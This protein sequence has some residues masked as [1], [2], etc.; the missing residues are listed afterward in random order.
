MRKLIAYLFIIIPVLCFG[1]DSFFS[2]GQV[3]KGLFWKYDPPIITVKIDGDNIELTG[4]DSVL[5]AKYDRSYTPTYSLLQS[6]GVSISFKN[7]PTILLNHKSPTEINTQ[8]INNKL[9]RFQSVR[10]TGFALQAVGFA[11]ALVGGFGDSDELITI[12]GIS[13]L[14]GW[15]IEWQSGS[16]LKDKKIAY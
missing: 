10:N 12:G 7:Q 6:S 3:T 9:L 1:Q 4:I 15:V 5:F 2:D 14:I 16:T 11:L 13:G 8:Y